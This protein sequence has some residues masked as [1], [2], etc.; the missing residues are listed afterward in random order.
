MI[1]RVTN[2]TPPISSPTAVNLEDK[3]PQPATK[4]RA[5]PTHRAMRPTEDKERS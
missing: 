3:R 4:Q 1:A 2:S 5:R